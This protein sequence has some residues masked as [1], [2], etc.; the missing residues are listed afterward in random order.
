MVFTGNGGLGFGSG[1]G[2]W[3]MATTA[4]VGSRR[5]NYPITI[6]WGSDEKYQCI[7][8]L[9]IRLKWDNFKQIN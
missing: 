8:N 6:C 2:A 3:E 1:E 7:I 9:I 4:K 5:V